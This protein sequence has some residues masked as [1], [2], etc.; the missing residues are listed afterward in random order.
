M[1]E[2]DQALVCCWDPRTSSTLPVTTGVGEAKS[3]APSPGSSPPISRAAGS[4]RAFNKASCRDRRACKSPPR[5]P[6]SAAVTEPPAAAASRDS[7]SWSRRFP[8]ART[9][10]RAADPARESGPDEPA[11]CVPSPAPQSAPREPPRLGGATKQA[12]QGG[13]GGGGGGG[14]GGATDLDRPRGVLQR[15]PRLL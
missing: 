15:A 9:R 4:L 13:L 14:G 5:R 6:A 2:Q 3:S 10:L 8:S 1:A 7:C 11:S 12:R